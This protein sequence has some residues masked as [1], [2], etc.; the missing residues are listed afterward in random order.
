MNKKL[1]IAEWS[2]AILSIMFYSG[3]PLPVILS[4]GH[5]EGLGDSA[6]DPTNYSAL[7]ALF[8]LNYLVT[9]GLLIFRWKRSLYVVSKEWTI[10]LLIGIAFASIMWSF[11]LKLTPNRSIELAGSTLFGFYLAARYSIREQ[12]KLLAWTFAM[13]IILSFFMAI[14]TPAY[15]TMSAGVHA[16]AWRGIYTHKNWFGRMMTIG[17]IVFLILAMDEKQQKWWYWMGFGCSFWLLLLSRSSSSILNCVTVFALIPIYSIFRWR[18]LILLPTV[19]AVVA[20]SSSLS[21]WFNENA[22][23]V[24]GSIGKDATLTGRTDMWPSIIEMI[25]KEPWLGYGY[26]AFWNDWNSP[27]AT[28]WYA[29]K[30]TPPNAHN[31]LLDLWLD[32]GLLGVV[33]FAI[34]FVIVLLRGLAWFRIDKSWQSFWPILFP[35]YLMLAN[36]SESSLLNFNEIFWVLYVSV[37]FSLATVDLR[38]NKVLT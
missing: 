22:A 38:T 15:G 30:W 36:V 34:S 16:G 35:T 27:G 19:I 24:L 18:Y 12:L 29:A 21:L 10:W 4:G 14:V 17:G 32:L 28:V 11:N 7:I 23:T 3:G 9:I 37:A 5:S 1:E 31:G 8:F 25:A 26:S 2:F 6:A 20:F 33:V 13:I